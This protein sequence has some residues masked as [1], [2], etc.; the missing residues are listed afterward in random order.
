MHVYCSRENVEYLFL[1]RAFNNVG[2][3]FS[4]GVAA[5]TFE[6]GKLI[7]SYNGQLPVMY[8]AITHVHSGREVGQPPPP[9]RNF[10]I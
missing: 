9:P 2:S 10:R 3:A 4:D 6:D 1:V 5:R 8:I 7:Y